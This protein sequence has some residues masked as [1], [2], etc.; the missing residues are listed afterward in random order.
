MYSILKEA[1]Q[2]G[3]RIFNVI[4]QYWPAPPP[5]VTWTYRFPSEPGKVQAGPPG[6]AAA[7]DGRTP[8]LVGDPGDIGRRG[9]LLI[10]HILSRLRDGKY[11][12]TLITVAAR[13]EPQE[14]CR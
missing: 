9:S 1:G 3:R 6:G 7:A 13:L 14:G 10:V 11:Y 5:E 8:P 4:N 12:T 2:A